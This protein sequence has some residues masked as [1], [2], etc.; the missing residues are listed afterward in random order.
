MLVK[1]QSRKL[2]AQ[3][4]L[5]CDGDSIV[6][7]LEWMTYALAALIAVVA[8]TFGSSWPAT[9]RSETSCSWESLSKI[10]DR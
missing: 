2:S 5:Q 10:A 1:S 8:L 7:P 6:G 9:M 4:A 3:L